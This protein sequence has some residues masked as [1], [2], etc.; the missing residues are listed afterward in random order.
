MNDLGL[1]LREGDEGSAI[2]DLHRRLA[3]AGFPPGGDTERFDLD[4]VKAVRAFQASRRIV[5]D[6]SV[7]RHTWNALVEADNRLGDRM[8]YLRSPMT[9][10]DDVNDLQQRLGSLGF[11][12]GYVDGIFG[13]DTEHAVRNFQANQGVTADGVVG[14]DT[15]AALARLAGRRS[16]EKT[17]A[18]VKEAEMLPA[19]AVAGSSS[20]RRVDFQ[21]L[22]TPLLAG[23]DL[24]GPRSSPCITLI[25]RSMPVPQ[26]TGMAPSTSASR[27][28]ITT[29]RSPISRLRASFPQAV[30]AL[31]GIPVDGSA[32]C[33]RLSIHRSACGCQSCARH[34]C[35]QSGV[36]SGA[37]P[38]SSSRGQHS[39]PPFTTR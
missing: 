19:S 2:R 24:T 13:P 3:A 26:T 1:P 34:G 9:R 7:G 36:G 32:K 15:I 35:Q 30:K 22:S 10:G 33:W 6:G 27:W 28:L 16:G 20:A 23:F 29:I 12:A 18:E 8:L 11:D 37:R 5:E 14:P 21:P 39:R 31:P 38:P 25:W 17:I 4:T